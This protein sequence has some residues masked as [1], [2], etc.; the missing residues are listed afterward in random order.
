[1]VDHETGVLS[2]PVKTDTLSRITLVYGF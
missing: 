2:G 1:V